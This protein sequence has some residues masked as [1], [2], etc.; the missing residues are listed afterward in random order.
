[1]PIDY[2]D[3]SLKSHK[4]SAINERIIVSWKISALAQEEKS[5]LTKL[6]G[7]NKKSNLKNEKVTKVEDVSSRTA[8]DGSTIILNNGILEL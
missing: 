8:P 7:L 6:K 2:D 5:C 3:E 4:I 1:L